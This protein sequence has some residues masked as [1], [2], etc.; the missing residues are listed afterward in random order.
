MHRAFLRS[1][2]LPPLKTKGHKH[3]K[4]NHRVQTESRQAE[5]DPPTVSLRSDLVAQLVA[6]YLLGR[7]AGIWYYDQFNTGKRIQ[8]L[9][10]ERYL[11]QE[12]LAVRLNVS[13][14]HLRSL[15]SGEYIPSIDLFIEIAAFFDV[16][17]DHLIM[18]K[19][20]SDQEESL[21]NKLQQKRLTNQKL[22]LKLQ[23][24]MQ[25]LSAIAEEL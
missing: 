15:E 11:T 2:R 22:R 17:L 18:G 6:A 5:S 25:K 4:E 1:A 20:L 16:T 9:R 3:E 21:R 7:R 8:K 19:S 24:I 14:R 12:E 13:D 23:R 10:R